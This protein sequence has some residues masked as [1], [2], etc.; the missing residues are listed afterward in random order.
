MSLSVTFQH[1]QVVTTTIEQL[2]CCEKIDSTVGS[3]SYG[4]HAHFSPHDFEDLCEEV[5]K[6][7]MKKIK[8]HLQNR[9][10][11][12]SPQTITAIEKT[13][14]ALIQEELKMRCKIIN[15]LSVRNPPPYNS[16]W[17]WLA[18]WCRGSN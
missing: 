12:L 5:T 8:A 10:E 16:L 4:I 15:P 17:K 3:F 6:L 11:V 14:S 7:A 18:S 9:E 13:A 2:L 1:Q